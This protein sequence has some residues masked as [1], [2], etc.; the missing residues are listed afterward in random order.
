MIYLNMSFW[1]P[2]DDHEWFRIHCLNH[3]IND[4][5]AQLQ[6]RE[7]GTD[8]HQCTDQQAGIPKLPN[9]PLW[10]LWAPAGFN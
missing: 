7:R 3:Y 6:G 2:S 8:L 9:K 4:H 5:I 1:T 10:D